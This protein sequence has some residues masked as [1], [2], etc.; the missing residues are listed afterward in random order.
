[1]LDRDPAGTAG[2]AGQVWLHSDNASEE[3]FLDRPCVELPPSR[4]H[5]YIHGPFRDSQDGSC[6]ERLEKLIFKLQPIYP[7]EP[8]NSL[9]SLTSGFRGKIEDRKS[10]W[11]GNYLT[12][13]AL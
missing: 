9:V 3:G 13:Q 8:A 12:T 5:S 7:S 6:Q 11:T 4:R 2:V 10:L 1:M